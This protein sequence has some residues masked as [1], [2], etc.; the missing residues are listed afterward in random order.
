MRGVKIIKHIPKHSDER[1]ETFSYVASQPSGAM[2]KGFKELLI[3][4]RKKGSIAGKH[5]HNGT[6]PTRNPEIQYVISGKLRLVVKDLGT[7]AK[8]SF[9]LGPDTEVRIS[10]NIYHHMEFLEDTVFLELHSEV[11]PYKDVHKIELNDN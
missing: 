7:G 9:V 5:Y 4:K 3:L 11:S 6:D 2:K 10:P 1:G 8:E